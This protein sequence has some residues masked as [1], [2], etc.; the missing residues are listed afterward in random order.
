M[1][2]RKEEALKMLNYAAR[3]NGKPEFT[4]AIKDVSHHESELSVKESVRSLLGK[5]MFNTTLSVWAIWFGFGFA[6]YGLVY[7]INTLFEVKS[8]YDFASIFLSASSEIFGVMIGFGL[9]DQI[10]RKKTQASTYL[11]GG[12]G[13]LIL[14]ILV[15]MPHAPVLLTLCAMLARIGAMAASCATWVSTPELYPTNIRSTGHSI[16]AASS[17]LGAALSPAVVHH[18]SSSMVCGFLFLINVGCAYLSMALPV[19]TAGQELDTPYPKQGGCE[20]G[21]HWPCEGREAV[22]PTTITMDHADIEI[23]VMRKITSPQ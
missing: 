1:V 3:L 22:S 13:T 23:P 18:F 12:V 17:R 7:L 16:A 20:K 14:G 11:L 15:W 21:E 2:G 9:I 4:C 10:G 19:E 6:Y 8:H 5:D